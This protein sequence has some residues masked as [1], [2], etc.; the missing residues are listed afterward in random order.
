MPRP[1]RTSEAGF[2]LVETVAALGILALAA[3]PLMQIANDAVGNT[4]RLESRLLART[5]AENVV[6]LALAETDPLDAGIRT[7]LQSQLGRAF[8]WTLSTGPS[9]S[10][11]VQTIEVQVTPVGGSQVLARLV[12][13]KALPAPPPIPPDPD[14]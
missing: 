8:A 5:V 2:S 6:S 9:E 14:S 4:G 10:G 1:D 3:L 7:G 11:G 12:S 13:L